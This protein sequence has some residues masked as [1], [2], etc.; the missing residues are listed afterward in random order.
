MLGSK[1]LTA[2]PTLREPSARKLA[3]IQA[4]AT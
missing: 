3:G 2:L 4:V 1:V